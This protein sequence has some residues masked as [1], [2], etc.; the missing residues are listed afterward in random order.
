MN[1]PANLRLSPTEMELVR[2]ADWLLTKNRIIDKVY[3]LLGDV[4]GQVRSDF[5]PAPKISRGENYQGLPWVMLDYPR[6][7]TREDVFAVRVFFW[8]GHFF[9]ITLHVKGS[10]LQ[11]HKTAILEQLPLLEKY[12]FHICISDD[13][14]RH[15]FTIDNFVPVQEVGY[16]TIQSMLDAAAFCRLSVKIP[17][18]EWDRVEKILVELYNVIF[19]VTGHQLPRR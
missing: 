12:N 10:F 7:F 5:G 13:E 18:E 17:L 16:T 19:T 2:N 9:S 8:W 4:A 14:W 6:Q 11:L 15:E 1:N 3:L